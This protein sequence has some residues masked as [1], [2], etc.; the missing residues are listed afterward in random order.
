MQQIECALILASQSPRRSELLKAAGLSF[1]VIPSEIDESRV[2]LTE[3][4]EYVKTLAQAKT[5]DIAHQYPDKWV[6]GADTIVLIDGQILGKPSSKTDARKMLKRLN[7]KLHQVMTSYAIGCRKAGRFFSETISTEVEFKK[8]TNEEIEWYIQTDEPFDKAGAY[9]IQ[10]LGVF[11]V[12]R[13]NGSYTNVVGLPVCEV[14]HALLQ[15][16]VINRHPLMP[17][18][19]N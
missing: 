11:M 12:K 16:G 5:N 19:M 2:T 9:A 3:P 15:E 10:G 7:G 14:V 18:R 8:L 1:Q 4:V 13:I 17:S 6:I